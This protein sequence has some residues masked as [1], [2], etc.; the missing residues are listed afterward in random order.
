MGDS[1]IFLLA[2]SIR[3]VMHLTVLNL[4]ACNL[5]EKGAHILVGLLKSLAVRRQADKWAWSLRLTPMDQERIESER[6]T[7]NSSNISTTAAPRPLKRLNL[8]KNKIGDYGCETLLDLVQEEVG[9]LALDLQMNGLTD[10][11]GIIAKS[12]LKNNIEIVILDLRNNTIDGELLYSVHQQLAENDKRAKRMRDQTGRAKRDPDLHWLDGTKPLKNTY[13]FMGSEIRQHLHTKSTLK[14]KNFASIEKP[15]KPTVSHRSNTDK[16]STLAAFLYPPKEGSKESLDDLK[17]PASSGVPPAITAIESHLAFRQAQK[18]K[19]LNRT[20]VAPLKPVLKK[21]SRQ[22]SSA[23]T[24]RTTQTK[25]EGIADPIRRLVEQVRASI[26]VSAQH[27]SLMPNRGQTEN[28]TSLFSTYIPTVTP[29]ANLTS[30]T[31]QSTKTQDATAKVDAIDELIKDSERID[32]LLAQSPIMLLK[33]HQESQAQPEALHGLETIKNVLLNETHPAIVETK[34][35]IDMTSFGI[36]EA[37]DAPKQVEVATTVNPTITEPSIEVR[38]LKENEDLK[39]RI[40]DLERLFKSSLQTPSVTVALNDDQPTAR[41]PQPS[42]LLLSSNPSPIQLTAP[43][44]NGTGTHRQFN[45]HHDSDGD[46]NA[47][48]SQ[49]DKLIQ[50]MESSLSNFQG[51][52]DQMDRQEERK[53]KKKKSS[54]KSSIL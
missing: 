53:K 33:M 15:R 28:N 48:A 14:K 29:V 54:R 2:P 10:K 6:A 3:T 51:M 25:G 5:T 19:H 30:A 31:N 23:P 1:G 26:P 44:T 42:P 21:T 43:L 39:S 38:L 13:H 41:P 16:I 46:S 24:Q 36:S 47:S 37:T 32:R 50:L 17:S 20:K 4:S 45:L 22:K 49:L 12:V 35:N 34:L 52:L 8:C 9:L 40:A 11:S 18:E 27:N 7:S